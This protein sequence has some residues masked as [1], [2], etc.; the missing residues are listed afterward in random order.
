MA[1]PSP[2]ENLGLEG[3]EKPP[4]GSPMSVPQEKLGEQL[5]AQASVQFAAELL[6]RSMF[7]LDGD[8]KDAVKRAMKT[9]RERFPSG[10]AGSRLVPAEI[11]Q[12]LATMKGPE[13]KPA[14]T[15]QQQGGMT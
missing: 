13:V 12:A 11:Q 4:R 7:N 9:L 2:S 6:E 10:S 3:A 5:G 8:E 15:N 1:T 14:E